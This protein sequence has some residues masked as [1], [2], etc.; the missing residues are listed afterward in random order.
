MTSFS[1]ISENY[2][3]YSPLLDV[4][5]FSPKVLMA[6]PGT[7]MIITENNISKIL[8]KASISAIL[9]IHTNLP[10]KLQI[11]W[12]VQQPADLLMAS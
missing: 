9:A 6:V 11:Q 3:S 1:L 10:L 7:S 8:Q 12:L 5:T 4:V 2:S